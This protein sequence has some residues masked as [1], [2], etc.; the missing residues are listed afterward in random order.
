MAGRVIGAIKK[1]FGDRADAQLVKKLADE[2]LARLITR[3]RRCR[4]RRPSGPSGPPGLIVT[5]AVASLD[6]SISRA[7]SISRCVVD[8]ADAIGALD[9]ARG[10]L[11]LAG[12]P[13]QQVVDALGV[14]RLVGV[15]EPG[16]DDLALAHQDLAGRAPAGR[17]QLE[18]A[19]LAL[20]LDQHEQRGQPDLREVAAEA[21][22]AELLAGVLHGRLRCGAGSWRRGGRAPRTGTA[23]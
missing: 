15:V 16:V 5:V 21:R 19:G 3:R 11:E 7:P 10:E 6:S 2:L 8:D 22:A 12:A 23:W 18:Q 4:R 20:H 17:A 13:G 1:Q 14:D 9:Q